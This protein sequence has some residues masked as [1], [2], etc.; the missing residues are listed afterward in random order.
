MI[1]KNKKTILIADSSMLGRSRLENIFTDG[2]HRVIIA[3][4]AME[5]VK[6]IKKKQ[7]IHLLLMD[8]HLHKTDGLRV[9][10][11]MNKNLSRNFPTLCMAPMNEMEKLLWKVKDLGAAG[12]ISKNMTGEIILETINTVLFSHAKKSR[13][14]KRKFATIPAKFNLGTYDIK[15]NILNISPGGL[16]LHTDMNLLTGSKVKVDFTLPNEERTSISATG[17]VKWA[18]PRDKKESLF[19]GVGIEFLETKGPEQLK[20]SAFFA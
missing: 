3:E 2:G 4:D 20:L 6:Q 5:L 11:W 19:S 17:T 13:T 12:I 1:T 18:T 7:N 10:E 14:K 8:M 15:A 16:F 9:L